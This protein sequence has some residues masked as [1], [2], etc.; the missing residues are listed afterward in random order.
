MPGIIAYTYE[1]AMHCP[2]CTRARF[3]RPPDLHR[4]ESFPDAAGVP[5]DARDCEGNLVHP[6][7]SIDDRNGTDHCD[8]CGELLI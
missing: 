6:V 7:S 2:D 3:A 8:T 1:A 5:M 4:P